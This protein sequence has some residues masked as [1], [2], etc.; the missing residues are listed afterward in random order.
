MLDKIVNALDRRRDLAGWTVRHL[1]TRGAQV[2]AVPGRIESERAV[3]LERYRIEVFRQTAASDGSPRMGNGD[4][5][6]LPGGDIEDAIENAALVA[7]LVSNPV[8]TLPG[9]APLPDI[10]LVDSDLQRDSSTVTKEV[11]ERIRAAA[12]KNGSVEL[13]AAECFGEIHATHLVNSRGVDARQEATQISIEVVLHSERGERDVETFTEIGRRRAADLDIE[14][15]IERR[16]RYS[17]DL[18]EAGPP[19][20]WQGAVVLREEA[21]AVFMAGDRLGGGVIQSLGSAASKYAKT[22]PWDVGKSIFQGEVKGDPLTVWAN[23]CIPFGTGSNRFDEEGI[24]AQRVELIRENE[25]VTFAASQRYA[26]YLNLP[27]TGA[28]GGVE[29]PPGKVQASTLL[30]EPYVEIIQFSWFNPDRIT[31]DFATEVR[32]GYFV[33]NGERKPFRG[34]Q[35]VGNYLD[36]LADVHWSAETGFFGNYLGPQMA[37]FNNL[38]IA[39]LHA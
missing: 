39:G 14:E 18:F 20:S 27:A 17:L 15:E 13:T 34:G 8:H 3:E 21:L 16:T 19:P 9:P 12:S 29:L 32:L 22:S 6:I 31:G 23:R 35:L 38:K 37:R 36:A 2:Y 11:M 24:P 25:L 5:T 28:F 10:P 30:A 33:E 26:D 1:N 7:G 4:A